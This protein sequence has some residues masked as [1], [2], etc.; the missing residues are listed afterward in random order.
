MKLLI[1]SATDFE[2][3][4]IM[5]F[6]KGNFEFKP[7]NNSFNKGNLKIKICISGIGSLMTTY[8]LSKS[9]VGFQPDFVVQLGVCGSF[10]KI[11]P[12]EE[13]VIVKSEIM[14]DTGAEDKDKL[15]DVFDLNL[16]EK[17]DF[18]FK[19]KK[20]INPLHQYPFQKVAPLVDAITVNKTAGKLET[21]SGR[22][23]NYN[24]DVESMEGA[25]LHYVCLQEKIP[26][27]Q[28]RSVSNYVEIRDKSKW[29]MKEAIFKLNKWFIEE[30]DFLIPVHSD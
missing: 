7:E 30:L 8:H 2:I 17:N 18:P 15:L 1:V 24:P 6:L 29:K 23:E 4:K 10:S 13:I 19:D 27:V 3:Q 22:I 5:E 25:A 14:G 26:F 16:I 9:I 12:L 28:I 11:T 21:I 20:L